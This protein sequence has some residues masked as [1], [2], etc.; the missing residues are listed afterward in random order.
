MGA[1]LRACGNTTRVDSRHERV[2]LT[3]AAKRKPAFKRGGLHRL[4]CPCC[5]TYGYYTVAM[6]EDA[7]LPVC[8]REGCGETL[9]PER[10]ELALLIGA[11]DAPVMRAYAS[12]VNSVMHGQAS[13]VQRGR[14]VE[15]PEWRALEAISAEQRKI[16]RA[17]RLSAL[18]PAPE[19]MPF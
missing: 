1:N 19:P 9:Q 13:H 18:A 6:L 5:P 8:W 17:R 3:V 10:L 2:G 7:G 4:V 16:S 11:D 12:K 14:D 15:S